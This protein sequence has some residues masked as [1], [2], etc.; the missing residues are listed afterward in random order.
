MSINDKKISGCAF[1]SVDYFTRK[2]VSTLKYITFLILCLT[3]TF[4]FVHGSSKQ[5]VFIKGYVFDASDSSGIDSASVDGICIDVEGEF[6]TTTNA[7]GYYCV[8]DS[9]LPSGGWLVTASATGYQSQQREVRLPNPFT[10]VNFY[11]QPT[12]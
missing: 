3:V 10:N 12:D 9:T 1:L 11:L 5:Q 4:L 2:E 6:H 7:L 8:I